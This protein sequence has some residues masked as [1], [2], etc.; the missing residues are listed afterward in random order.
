MF[1]GRAMNRFVK[2]LDAYMRTRFAADAATRS[3]RAT[4]TPSRF[5]MTPTAEGGPENVQPIDRCLALAA[6]WSLWEPAKNRVSFPVI[7]HLPR[8][9]PARERVSV[10]T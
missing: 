9:A 1:F 8:A 4:C 10:A 3:A 7:A 5:G 6:L 2:V